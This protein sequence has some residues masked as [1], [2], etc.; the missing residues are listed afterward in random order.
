MAHVRSLCW[1]LICNA[2]LKGQ[3]TLELGT[4]RGEMHCRL[5]GMHH[6]Q[7]A[8]SIAAGVLLSAICSLIVY[9]LLAA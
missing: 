2:Q 8:G 5:P 4:G 3:G 1:K 7:R 9:S 6:R